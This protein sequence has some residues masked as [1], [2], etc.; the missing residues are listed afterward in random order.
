MVIYNKVLFTE[1]SSSN[2]TFADHPVPDPHYGTARCPIVENML[3]P[4]IFSKPY[5]LTS[6]ENFQE[7]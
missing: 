6:P 3:F 2:N 4:K 1:S 5:I 7:S